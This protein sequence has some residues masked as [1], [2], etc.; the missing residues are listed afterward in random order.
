MARRPES[1]INE[2]QDSEGHVFLPGEHAEDAVGIWPNSAVSVRRG[3]ELITLE[4]V[5]VEEFDKDGEQASIKL[6]PRELH[7]KGLPDVRD[8]RLE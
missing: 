1:I 7:A 2:Q 6:I 8:L 3:N 4:Y 5:I